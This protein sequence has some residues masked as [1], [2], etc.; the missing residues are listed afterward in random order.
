MRAPLAQRG[1]EAVEPR[2][3]LAATID[4]LDSVTVNNAKCEMLGRWNYA[5]T[6]D[7]ILEACA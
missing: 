7:G 3:K 4:T 5:R 1:T 6:W 2:R